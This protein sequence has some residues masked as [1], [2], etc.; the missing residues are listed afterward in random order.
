ME[1]ALNP[2]D[3]TSL[4]QHNIIS[5]GECKNLLYLIDNEPALALM[6][7]RAVIEKIIKY[8]FSHHIKEPLTRKLKFVDMIN[9]LNK[10]NQ[11]TEYIF[12]YITTIRIA[13]NQATHGTVPL[14]SEVFA[15]LPMFYYILDWFINNP[16]KNLLLLKNTSLKQKH[17]KNS[18]EV[19][20]ILSNQLQELE[21]DKKISKKQQLEN[22]IQQSKIVI[23]NLSN[24]LLIYQRE[25]Q[26]ITTEINVKKKFLKQN[27]ILEEQ[28]FK[29]WDQ[30][31]GKL[32]EASKKLQEGKEWLEGCEQ[33]ILVGGKPWRKKD[34]QKFYDDWKTRAQNAL[35]FT[36]SFEQDYKKVKLVGK[37]LTR[38][39]QTMKEQLAELQEIFIRPAQ[40]N[41]E[42]TQKTNQAES[43]EYTKLIEDL[44]EIKLK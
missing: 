34:C 14:Q 2:P 5:E 28:K 12:N 11:F 15:V 4:E 13:G 3:L 21:L 38:E 29:D 37:N 30:A 27:Q 1:P 33:S 26:R 36:N 10:N 22:A 40:I 20:Q 6:K 31:L 42:N 24:S 18:D 35:V 23:E 19:I 9:R 44:N 16:F 43:I 8:Q 32:K 39:L 25:Q 7:M 17:E 41:L